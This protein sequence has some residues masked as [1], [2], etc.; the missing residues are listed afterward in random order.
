MHHPHLVGGRARTPRD[1]RAHRCRAR[2]GYALPLSARILRRPAPAHRAG[3]RAGA[4]ADLHRARRAD[5]RAR[6]AD[7]VAD[8]RSAARPAEEARSHLHVHL[9]RSARGGGAG[10]PAC[11]C[12]AT[13]R[14]WRRAQRPICSRTRRATTRARC[15][16]PPSTWRPRRKAWWRNDAAPSAIVDC[17]LCGLGAAAAAQFGA[18]QYPIK[19]DDGEAIAN[20]ALSADMSARLAKLPG[21]VA[22]GN[23]Q[24]DVT[25]LQFYD[26]NCPYCREA[27]ADVDALVR[28]DK[29]TQTGVRALRGVVGGLG[30][31]R[32][33]RGRRMR[34]C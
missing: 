9:A 22:V 2:S 30:A 8:G 33:D 20:F 3:A 14:W 18:S 13:A 28:A 29:Q 15:L 25:L 24:G 26:L 32:A 7:P 27:A 5:Q 11:W 34:K 19:A 6:H 17:V 21:Q 1:G 10:E 4:G 23:L 16:P 12:C 31:R